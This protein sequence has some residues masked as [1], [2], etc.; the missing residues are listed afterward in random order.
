MDTEEMIA[1]AKRIHPVVSELLMD[2]YP[3]RI[4]VGA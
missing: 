2:G 4:V 1:A 3:W